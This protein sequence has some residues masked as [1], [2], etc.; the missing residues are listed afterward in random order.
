[1]G[2]YVK[3]TARRIIQEENDHHPQNTV[4]TNKSDRNLEQNRSKPT[5]YDNAKPQEKE[6]NTAKVSIHLNS[7]CTSWHKKAKLII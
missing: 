5:P 2:E 3:E 6:R 1:L 7:K 4:K